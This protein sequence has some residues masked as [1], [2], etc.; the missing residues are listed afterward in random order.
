MRPVP[1]ARADLPE[2]PGPGNTGLRER[3]GDCCQGGEPVAGAVHDGDG[4]A[5]Q[6][7]IVRARVW[8][9]FPYRE[10]GPR[11]G[12]GLELL[13]DERVGVVHDLLCG[14]VR[15]EKLGCRPGRDLLLLKPAEASDC[16]REGDY[17]GDRGGDGDGRAAASG[18][19]PGRD[20]VLEGGLVDGPLGVAGEAAQI[21]HGLPP[22]GR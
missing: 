15:H 12:F 13:D 20:H 10:Y 22:R 8:A 14:P 11:L 19:A 9:A 18:S 4:F 7:G 21:R 17:G 3:V 2:Q 1:E 5:A 16:Q 6:A